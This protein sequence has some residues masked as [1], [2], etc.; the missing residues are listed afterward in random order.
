[1]ILC[2]R[3]RREEALALTLSVTCL[4]LASILLA[5]KR[6]PAAIS[7]WIVA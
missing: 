6:Y 7:L 3:L 5:K 4:T 1:M 2:D